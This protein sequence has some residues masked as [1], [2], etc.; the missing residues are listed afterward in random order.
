VIAFHYLPWDAVILSVADAFC[1][2]GEVEEEL[3]FEVVAASIDNPVVVVYYY[4]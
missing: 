3:P 2:R 1:L 4:C